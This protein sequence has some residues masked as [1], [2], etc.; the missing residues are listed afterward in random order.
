MGALPLVL[1]LAGA[2]LLSLSALSRQ[3]LMGLAGTAALVG[4][5]LFT[6]GVWS[7]LT[8]LNTSSNQSLPAAY[9]GQTAG[10]ANGGGMQVDTHCW[11]TCKPTRRA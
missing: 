1:F 10:P 5:L 11:P 8:T 6:P 3:R 9:G 7:A 4:A 2:A